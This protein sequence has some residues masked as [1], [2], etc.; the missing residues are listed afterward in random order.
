MLLLTE[1]TLFFLNLT[2]EFRSTVKSSAGQLTGRRINDW[3]SQVPKSTNSSDRGLDPQSVSGSQPASLPP[4]TIFSHS[5]VTTASKASSARPQHWVPDVPVDVQVEDSLVGGFGDADVDDSLYE[6]QD[7]DV[8]QGV[9][10]GRAQ[11]KVR[12]PICSFNEFAFLTSH[13]L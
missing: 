5:N 3:A 9:E 8:F 7:H 12:R 6:C 13:S 1:S 11:T 2:S 4:S 10:R